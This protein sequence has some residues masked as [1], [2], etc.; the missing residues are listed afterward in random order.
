MI[1]D[2]DDDDGGDDELEVVEL[3]GRVTFNVISA[4]LTI[5]ILSLEQL[6]EQNTI[7]WQLYCIAMQKSNAISDHCIV[8]LSSNSECVLTVSLTKYVLHYI[9]IPSNFN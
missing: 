7:L 8:I 6:W 4:S 1:D 3:M 5:A 2:D 9:A